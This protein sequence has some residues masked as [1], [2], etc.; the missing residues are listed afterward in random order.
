MMGKNKFEYF[1]VTADIGVRV[2]GN[3]ID[4]LFEMQLLR[5]RV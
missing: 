1:D 5:S 2:W 3:T 4:E